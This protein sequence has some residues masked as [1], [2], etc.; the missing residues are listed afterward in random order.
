MWSQHAQSHVYLSSQKLNL[1]NDRGRKYGEFTTIVRNVFSDL[2]HDSGVN[3]LGN[4]VYG[5]I[6][7][8]STSA[9]MEGPTDDGPILIHPN[10]TLPALP[11]GRLTAALHAYYRPSALS[12][13]R[14]AFF[15]NSMAALFITCSCLALPLAVLSPS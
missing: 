13:R 9:R 7:L 10:L 8:R 15:I 2:K 6:R 11:S 3:I 12:V 4:H 1:F 5:D 14:A